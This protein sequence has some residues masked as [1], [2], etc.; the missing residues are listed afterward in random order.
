[1]DSVSKADLVVHR[2]P[3][4]GGLLLL[5]LL[6]LPLVLLLLLLLLPLVLLAGCAQGSAQQQLPSV[7]GLGRDAS[8]QPRPQ[9]LAPTPCAGEKQY[10]Y[11]QY[12]QDAKDKGIP[13]VSVWNGSAQELELG[14]MPVLELYAGRRGVRE[15]VRRQDKRGRWR[16]EKRIKV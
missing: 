12:R 11:D 5:L 15:A 10:Y 13:F 7:R 9:S 16:R 4:K 2:R 8:P 14:L 1:V 6:L 3:R